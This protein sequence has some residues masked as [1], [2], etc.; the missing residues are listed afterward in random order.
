MPSVPE[1]ASDQVTLLLEVMVT[2]WPAEAMGA[3]GV[4]VGVCA[5]ANIG[6]SKTDKLVRM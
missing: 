5:N 3:E 1:P 2:D 4:S 6:K